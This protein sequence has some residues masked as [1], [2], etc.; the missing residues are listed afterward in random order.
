M[1]TPFDILPRL[2]QKHSA[3]KAYEA[4]LQ[5][6]IVQNI[7]RN[8]S[9]DNAL[10][11]SDNVEWIGSE[12]ACGVGMQRIDLMV[13]KSDGPLDRVVMPIE[14]KAVP[15]DESNITQISRYVD[16]V[17]QYYVPNRI[18]SFNQAANG[19]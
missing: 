17:E 19:R 4:H 3:R 10:G 16:W 5:M 1:M 15:A 12:V 18:I 13:S 14:L 8:P 2:I 6:Y 9:I 11:I 7:G